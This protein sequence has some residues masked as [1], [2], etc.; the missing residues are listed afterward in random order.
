MSWTTYVVERR[1]GEHVVGNRVQVSMSWTTYVVERRR[2]EH[3]GEQGYKLACR[4][5]HMS[6]KRVVGNIS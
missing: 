2:G 4:G 3:R 6:W 1:R 5:Q